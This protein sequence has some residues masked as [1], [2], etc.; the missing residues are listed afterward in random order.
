MRVEPLTNTTSVMSLEER[1]AS[2]RL[3]YMAPRVRS[4]SDLVMF[5][6]VARVS[7]MLRCLGAP[8]TMVINGS[9][10]LVTCEGPSWPFR[11]LFRR[12]RAMDLCADP[13]CRSFGFIGH[14]VDDCIIKIVATEV[15]ITGGGKL[16]PHHHQLQGETSK[17]PP[18]R[19][20]TAIFSLV[21]LSRP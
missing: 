13:C 3:G 18:P 16:P 8:S 2:F 11:W 7:D 9:R 5:S 15:A 4:I 6:N 1:P 10:L 19:S 14:V 17:V 12:C 21:F 20:Y